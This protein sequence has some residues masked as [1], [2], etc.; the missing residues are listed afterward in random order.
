MMGPKFQKV[1]SDFTIILWLSISLNDNLNMGQ[2]TEEC[3]EI[4]DKRIR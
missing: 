3:I 2:Y 1:E 4:L